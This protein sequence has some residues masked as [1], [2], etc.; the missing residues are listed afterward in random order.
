MSRPDPDLPP[1]DPD[2]IRFE[3][4]LRSVPFRPVPAGWRPVWTRTRPTGR[5][6]WRE[7]L[8]PGPRFWPAMAAAWALVIVLSLEA[9]RLGRPVRSD[10][11]RMSPSV[12]RQQLEVRRQLMAGVFEPAPEPSKPLSPGGGTGPRSALPPGKSSL[13]RESRVPPQAWAGLVLA[14]GN[15]RVGNSFGRG[16]GERGV[17]PPVEV[18]RAIDEPPARAA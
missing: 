5:P 11:P 8:S 17:S 3:E 7:L 1:A 16:N 15:G 4:R 6:W 13:G 2:L 12:V 18:Q 9:E 14:G 10:L